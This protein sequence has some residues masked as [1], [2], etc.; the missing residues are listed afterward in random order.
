MDRSSEERPEGEGLELRRSATAPHVPDSLT[1]GLRRRRQAADKYVT[2]SSQL[3]L[4][5][6]R[7]RRLLAQ[8]DTPP[9]PPPLDNSTLPHENNARSVSRR[10]RPVSVPLRYNL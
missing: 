4:R 3:P 2:D 1:P 9:R 5:F 7:P 10:L 6:Q 8:D